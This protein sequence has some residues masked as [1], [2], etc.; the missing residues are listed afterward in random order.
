MKRCPPRLLLIL[1]ILGLLALTAW[2]VQKPVDQ[3]P[4]ASVPEETEPG[5]LAPV[6]DHVPD[7]IEPAEVVSHPVPVAHPPHDHVHEEPHRTAAS[8]AP[9]MNAFAS[10]TERYLDAPDA[11]TRKALTEEG[12]QLAE[13]RRDVL[14]RMIQ[15]DPEQ[16]LAETLPLSVRS[17][18]PA[19]IEELLEDRV[20]GMVDMEVVC[21]RPE[22]GHDH[23]HDHNHD[24]FLRTATMGD[25]DYR[26]FVYG[27]RLGHPGG[28]GL[29]LHG[30]S[31]DS[32]GDRVLAVD[33]SPVRE[34]EPE[35]VEIYR[36]DRSGAS[37]EGS[38]CAF[39][40]HTIEDDAEVVLVDIGGS[41]EAVCTHDHVAAM[42]ENLLTLAYLGQPPGGVPS[43]NFTRATGRKRVIFYR[44][45]FADV[46]AP[47][48]TLANAQNILVGANDYW[49]ES[50]YGMLTVAPEGEGSDIVLVTLTNNAAVYDGDHG[51][52]RNE[53][54][55][56]A[57]AQGYDLSQYDFRVFFTGGQ[58]AFPWC[59]LGTVGGGNPWSMVRCLNVG[60][61][62]HELGHNIGL[63]HGNYWDTDD[64]SAMG[65]GQNAEYGDS[66][67]VM[68]G[69]GSGGH[70]SVKFKRQV[71]WVYDED[72]PTI[73]TNGRYRVFTLDNVDTFGIRGLRYQ[74][75][76]SLTWSHDDVFLEF[77][78]NFTGNAWL[79]NG[80][81]VRWGYSGGG[82]RSQLVDTTPGSENNKNDS[83]VVLGRTF[84]DVDSEVYITPVRFGN[85]YP[86]S[87][88]VQV[89]FGPFPGNQAPD[90]RLEAGATSTTPGNAITFTATAADPDG[91]ELAYYWD[92]GDRSVNDNSPTETHAWNSAGDYMARCTVSDMK[93][94]VVS[95]SVLIQVG[96]PTTFRV[97]G[98]VYDNGRPVEGV[99]V[100]A[101]NNRY[102]YTDSDG[103]YTITRLNTGNYTLTAQKY[104]YLFAKPWFSNP[105]NVG[106]NNAMNK[107]FITVTGFDDLNLMAMNALWH[108]LDDGSDQG[109]VWKDVGFDD[110]TWAEGPAEL[111]Y[112]DTGLGTVV[113]FGPDAN[114][115]HITTYFR[116]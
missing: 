12:L 106:P 39:E 38:A 36:N 67:D 33:E 60:V 79:M 83:A 9:I 28:E 11:S 14:F 35:E 24:E 50:S 45:A 15:N 74:P 54:Q 18:L 37:F 103:T 21:V 16:A 62:M 81:G 100:K 109:T 58:P 77:R 25:I 95:C 20:S 57:V 112:G 46:P 19:A 72:Y 82:G 55:A 93:G 70:H 108:Y 71:G 41:V 90:L 76:Q 116:R 52:V 49:T 97:S 110:S 5:P 102:D 31:L 53:S 91:D 66:F 87:I 10:W 111:G 34:L 64:E 56:D 7:V 63:L 59:G 42:E 85:T 4:V 101:T 80:L 48:L 89:N 99:L 29:P 105:V 40:E 43:F 98:R 94:G 65:P 84:A 86:E 8:P 96:T 88:D 107:D 6:V 61:T 51:R 68:G 23:D 1:P 47:A 115:K 26:A 30:I 27:E 104:P 114:N 32:D 13:E 69:A 22:P 75:T 17:Q 113:D 73:S 3:T 78:Q 44:I 2:W 92:F